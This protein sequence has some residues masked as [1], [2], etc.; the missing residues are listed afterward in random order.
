MTYFWRFAR[1]MGRHRVVLTLAVVMA[2]VSAVGMGAGIL[3]IVPLLRNILGDEG[4]TLPMLAARATEEWG[5]PIPEGWVDALPEG[6]FAAVLAII[7]ALGALTL[8]GA[9][10]NF[11]H[12]WL[13]LT[14]SVRT[15]GDIRRDTYRSLLHMPLSRLSGRTSDAISRMLHDTDMLLTGFNALTSRSVAEVT[16][17]AA[18]LAAAF[19]LSWRLTLVGLIVAPLLYVIIRKLGK[20]VRRASRGAMRAK[21]DLLSVSSESL[22]GL[23]VVKVFTN[24]RAELGR[25]TRHN[26]DAVSAALRA[27]TARALSTPLTEAVTIFI[28]GGMAI[29]AAKA[30]I[31]GRME[32]SSFIVT[33]AALSAAGSAVKPL[34]R[35]VQQIQMSEAA[36]AR[37]SELLDA[38][39]EPLWRRGRRRP[40]LPRHRESIAFDGVTFTYPG[41]ETPALRDVRLEVG[42][43]ET[44]AVVGP[45][46]SGKTTLLSL[47]PRLFEPDSGRV[48]IDGVDVG[49][50]DLRALRRQIAV[51]TQEVVLFA[52]T[53][54]ENIAYGASG[55]S[56]EAVVE[57]ARRAR[58]HEFIER[59]PGGYDALLGEGGLS[60]SGGQRQRLAIA[61]AILRNPSIL[62]LDEATS[63]IDADSERQIA[64]AL[65]EFTRGRTCLVVAHRLST[66]VR[67]DRIVVMEEGTV[68]DQGRHE[69]LLERCRTYRL[70]AQTQLA[71]ATA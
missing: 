18:A 54:A 28:L 4:A 53:I 62:I 33:L 15:I 2:F 64:E 45:N 36:A 31:D 49:G 50:V 34:S 9:A 57:A 20:R 65:E 66:V 3:G 68:I 22:H 60:L 70:L 23:R 17:G 12:A 43:G 10:A 11:L 55:A 47:I 40:R 24:E 26:R 48:L 29:V 6:R 69:D 21:A 67:A 51:V 35:A 8:L 37:L 44:V 19:I 52:G 38:E 42:H 30:I 71:P 32:L 56:R 7:S 16:K 13:S 41:A 58:A 63:M 5:A 39:P 25:F 59:L 61:R 14:A 1:R 46:G 27:R